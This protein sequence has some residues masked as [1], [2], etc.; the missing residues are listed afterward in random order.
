[1]N[2]T[3]EKTSVTLSRDVLRGID[4][5]AGTKQSRSAFIE[6]VLREYLRART[7]AEIE[8]H[9]IEALNRAAGDLACEIQEVLRDQAEVGEP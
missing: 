9:D 6:L 3:K 2:R 7:Q 1:M 4:R 5:L 8:A